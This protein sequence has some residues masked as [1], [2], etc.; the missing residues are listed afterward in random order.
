MVSP[1]GTLDAGTLVAL[2]GD[3]AP[4]IGFGGTATTQATAGKCN[5]G[6][7]NDADCEPR[8]HVDNVHVG[9][10]MQDEIYTGGAAVLNVAAQASNKK[11]K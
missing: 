9:H 1:N 11:A 8:G 7:G 4:L 10:Q 6:F 2:T 3:V 5:N